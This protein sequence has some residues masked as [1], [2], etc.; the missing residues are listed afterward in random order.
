MIWKND[1]M[2]GRFT[3]KT[4]SYS[5][6]FGMTL[7]VIVCLLLTGQVTKA[8]FEFGTPMKL[9]PAVNGVGQADSGVTI[10]HDGLSLYFHSSRPLGMS[11]N[12][13]IW[14]S[15]R[16]SR[17]DE[18]GPAESLGSP[19][20][21][22]VAELSPC[23]SADGLELYLAKGPVQQGDADI[24][25]ARRNSPSDPWGAPVNLGTQVNGTGPSFDVAPSVT[26]DGLELYFNSN[27]SG[28]TGI[29]V[30][31][32]ATTDDPWGPAT[33]LGAPINSTYNVNGRGEVNAEISPDGLALFFGSTR[34]APGRPFNNY[35]VARRSSR[36]SEWQTPVLLETPPEP[37]VLSIS[38]D[39]D[40]LYFSSDTPEGPMLETLWQTKIRPVV[41][42][43]GDTLVDIQDLILLIEHWG[44]SEPAF[45]IGPAPLGDGFVDAADLEVLM[46][47]FGRIVD[48][49][50]LAHWK[51]DQ[52]GGAVAHDSA[53]VDGQAE[54]ATLFGDP[55]W[56]AQA[57][58]LDG[59]LALDGM[60]DYLGTAFLV[61]P[62][63]GPFSVF[64]WIKGDAPDQVVVSQ[65]DGRDWLLTDAQGY[66]MTDLVSDG[67]RSGGPLVSDVIVTDN[68]WHRVG[69]TW[70]GATR[71]LYVDDFVAGHDALSGLK[72]SE[73]GLRI[74][75]GKGRAA[76]SFWSGM[77][78]DVRVYSRAVTP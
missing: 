21:S 75:T 50:L 67:R 42:F 55:V 65:E 4:K 26:A 25:V 51:L 49:T 19:I 11:F 17:G 54:D 58:A 74:G 69:V 48:P 6:I 66:L 18:W 38:F 52:P 9:G 68:T 78:D 44:Q 39:Q 45:D 13:D 8:D 20:N 12:A 61:D 57:G 41:D 77:V 63:N 1:L 76:S 3:M 14:V 43:N 15:T 28:R 16:A 56:V 53:S 7:A 37:T 23:L 60:D 40:V 2:K 64:A 62:G 35:Y 34:P 32:R 73:G 59:A 29:Y 10:S 30:C 22:G 24:H 36:E 70:D 33:Y 31:T 46:A 27:R 71:T 5:Q 72:S 47:H